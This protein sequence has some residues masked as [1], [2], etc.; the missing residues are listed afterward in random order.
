M[1]PVTQA[2][3]AGQGTGLSGYCAP[4]GTGRTEE[5][6]C[7]R[8]MCSWGGMGGGVRRTRAGSGECTLAFGFRTGIAQACWERVHELHFIIPKQVNSRK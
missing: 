2:T 5:G 8:I 3:Q 1:A 4:R 7:A 6:W